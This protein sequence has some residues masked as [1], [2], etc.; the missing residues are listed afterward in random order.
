MTLPGSRINMIYY[1]RSCIANPLNT[2]LS[3]MSWIFVSHLC[4]SDVHNNA[5]IKEATVSTRKVVEHKINHSVSKVARTA[6]SMPVW[7]S[8]ESLLSSSWQDSEWCHKVVWKP[9]IQMLLNDWKNNWLRDWYFAAIW[10]YQTR[11]QPSVETLKR[12]KRLGIS[13]IKRY[14]KFWCFDRVSK[15][16]IKT[17]LSLQLLGPKKGLILTLWFK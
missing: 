6:A 3:R 15:D 1:N 5:S 13:L 16:A 10:K 2:A 11:N 7:K 17:M 14:I 9:E 4:T 12:L 8:K